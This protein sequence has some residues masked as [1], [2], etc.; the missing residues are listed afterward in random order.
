MAK[1]DTEKS[2]FNCYFQSVFSD[3]SVMPDISDMQETS[4][5]SVSCITITL[6]E[7]YQALV[8]LD[9]NTAFGFDN[10]SPQ[11]LQSCASVLCEPLHHLFMMSNIQLSQK[12]RS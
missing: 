11:I 2:L 6:A 10:I 9:P 5:V 12:H 1:S 3:A 4:P 7:V 8:S